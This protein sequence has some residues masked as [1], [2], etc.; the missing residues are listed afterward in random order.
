MAKQKKL[1]DDKTPPTSPVWTADMKK[2]F[3]QTGTYRAQDLKRVLGEPGSCLESKAPTDAC[4]NLLKL[5]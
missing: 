4:F 1:P 3:Q 5:T 2:Y